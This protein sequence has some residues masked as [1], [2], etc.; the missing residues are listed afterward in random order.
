MKRRGQVTI[1]VVLGLVLLLVMIFLFSLSQNLQK[2]QSTRLVEE[3]LQST[4]ETPA[5]QTYVQSCLQRVSVEGLN[6]ITTQGG[7]L[8]NDQLGQAISISRFSPHKYVLEEV[9]FGEDEKLVSTKPE[10]ISQVNFG[11]RATHPDCLSFEKYAF[12]GTFS[13]QASKYPV[14]DVLFKDYVNHFRRLSSLGGCGDA[15]NPQSSMGGYLGSNAFPKLCSYNGL[16]AFNVSSI[17]NCNIYDY[18]SPEYNYSIQ[19]QLEIYIKYNLPKCINFSVFES[20]AID[21]E[22]YED[23]LEIFLAYKNPKGF[24]VQAR[25][26]IKAQT[27]QQEINYFADFFTEVNYDI[28]SLYYY[29]SRLIIEHL[30][31]PLFVL[32]KDYNTSSVLQRFYKSY[33][34][35]LYEPQN[36]PVGYLDDGDDGG[37][38]D[39]FAQNYETIVTPHNVLS[40]IDTSEQLNNQ[41]LRFNILIE[42]RPPILNYLIQGGSTIDIYDRLVHYQFKAG[43]QILFEPEGVDPDGDV[44]YFNYSGWRQNYLTK[45]NISCCYKEFSKNPLNCILYDKDEIQNLS[46]YEFKTSSS[47]SS[48]N[49][50]S[51]NGCFTI[52][53]LPE[54]KKISEASAVSGDVGV[55]SSGV[56]DL[57]LWINSQEYKETNSSAQISSNMD[58]VGIHY[59]R[60]AIIDEYDQVDFQ[61]IEIMVF[62]LPQAIVKFFNNYSDINNSFASIEDMYYV[63]ASD[64]LPSI[65][66]GGGSLVHLFNDTT[67]NIFIET[68]EEIFSLS[69]EESFNAIQSLNFTKAFFDFSSSSNTPQTHEILFRVKQTQTS[70]SSNP[71][72]ALTFYSDPIN[73]NIVVA[74]CLPH[75]YPYDFSVENYQTNKYPFLFEGDNLFYAPHV[76]CQPITSQSGY[77]TY[78]VGDEDEEKDL[79]GPG[80]VKTPDNVCFSI[81]KSAYLTCA[82]KKANELLYLPYLLKDESVGG[83]ISIGTYDYVGVLNKL[84]ESDGDLKNDIFS[85]VVE[86]KCSGLRGNTCGGDVFVEFISHQSCNDLEDISNQFARCQ[87]PAKLSS[88]NL[89]EIIIPINPNS[90]GDNFY[91]EQ[92]T[93]YNYTSGQSFEKTRPELF[94][95]SSEDI[96]NKIEQGFCAPT[97]K[98]QIAMTTNG[99]F[100]QP[101]NTNS[102]KYFCDATCNPFTGACEYH[103][104]N[105]CLLGGNIASDC[106]GLSANLFFDVEA[107]KEFFVCTDQSDS[108]ACTSSGVISPAITTRAGCYCAT[109]TSFIKPFSVSKDVSFHEYFSSE[110]N[111]Y[112]GGQCCL[113]GKYIGRSNSQYDIDGYGD[114]LSS[115]CINGEIELAP[116]D[117][118]SSLDNRVLIKDSQLFCCGFGVVGCP[119]YSVGSSDGTF[120]CG[121]SGWQTT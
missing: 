68:N 62:D 29:T 66:L 38:G 102:V 11:V 33:Y 70:F 8:T 85:V 35:V 74:Q 25:L 83:K 15:K 19:R 96:K 67:E 111:P 88:N 105:Y 32:E 2:D 108:K 103:D 34:K 43:T 24:I 23:N 31:N 64:S 112:S 114:A 84:D 5:I 58:D 75:G 60:I 57:D 49:L 46:T 118:I 78:I 3:S 121:Q 39:V 110:Y 54:N 51:V 82:P 40:V 47:V 89:P 77:G 21:F 52:T 18:D 9:L 95:E 80:Y 119:Y 41:P 87:A 107:E 97:K 28:Q 13:P 92:F 30:R 69:K 94:T 22:V 42:Q 81:D 65:L 99:F 59:M 63:D 50:I 36:K 76:C 12:T 37:D 72:D 20:D 48:N 14:V 7:Y 1:F 117:K 6:L 104:L 45:I 116:E 16:N 53:L 79:L 93:C 44:V 98:Y 120:I 101:I 55:S 71:D 27:S 56:D 73:T 115:V 17:A 4:F 109:Q 10:V 106:E 91:G 100:M 61:D 86:Q 113:P 90:C 26:P